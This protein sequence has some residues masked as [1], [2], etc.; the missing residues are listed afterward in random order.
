MRACTHVECT[1]CTDRDASDGRTWFCP[2]KSTTE[3]ETTWSE[4]NR[5]DAVSDR[6]RRRTWCESPDTGLPTARQCGQPKDE[7]CQPAPAQ[8]CL[9]QHEHHIDNADT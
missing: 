9:Q 6:P 5:K 8:R 4:D 3:C 2:D 7:N 1:G